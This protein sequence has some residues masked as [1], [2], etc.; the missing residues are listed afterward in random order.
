MELIKKSQEVQD[1]L[2]E[3]FLQKNKILVDS[4]VT[5]FQKFADSIGTQASDAL[6]AGITDGALN[7]FGNFQSIAKGLFSNIGNQGLNLAIK[8]SF[9]FLGSF[10]AGGDFIADRPSF[11]QV[12]EA[13]A[14]RVRVEP[15][16]GSRAG[17]SG[18]GG[19]GCE[20]INLSLTVQGG[21]GNLSRQDVKDIVKGAYLEVATRGNSVR[22][23]NAAQ[24]KRSLY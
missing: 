22:R 7:G 2:A 8:A 1:Q 15:L 10:T 9:N 11:I 3:N 5:E 6:A 24:S 20:N 4:G 21:L 18:D 12:G 16:T 14:E 19:G 17:R 13:G 23:L